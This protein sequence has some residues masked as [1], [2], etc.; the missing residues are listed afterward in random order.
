MISPPTMEQRKSRPINMCNSDNIMHKYLSY[1]ALNITY[2]TNHKKT[3]AGKRTGNRFGFC[4]AGCDGKN[5]YL[6]PTGH[7]KGRNR[8]ETLRQ[9][10]IF[11]IASFSRMWSND[12]RY[13]MWMTCIILPGSLCRLF[14]MWFPIQ[15]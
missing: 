7:H 1:C 2:E 11:L 10:H 13:G 3:K 8:S 4:Q 6:S 15:N 5:R 12:I 9:I 14:L